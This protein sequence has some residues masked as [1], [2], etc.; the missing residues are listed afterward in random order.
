MF[1]KLKALGLSKALCS[2]VSLL[3]SEH[4][5]LPQLSP[6]RSTHIPDDCADMAGFSFQDTNYHVSFSV[7]GYLILIIILILAR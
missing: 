7:Y 4:R 5:I 3:F 6:S 1:N 2:S